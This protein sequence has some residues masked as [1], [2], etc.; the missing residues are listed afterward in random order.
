MKS[1]KQLLK[2]LKTNISK[3]NKYRQKQYK[4]G[5][6]RI[7]LQYM[8]LKFLD[9]TEVDFYQANLRFSD[10]YGANLENANLNRVILDF[11][12]LK[13]VNLRNANL[14]DAW[15]GQHFIQVNGIGLYEQTILYLFEDDIIICKD[16]KG[17]LKE[18]KKRIKEDYLDPTRLYAKQYNLFFENIKNLKKL[19][20]EQN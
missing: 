4:K 20:N 12:D 17:S 6:F 18:F 14:N 2:L 7:D 15:I 13:N 19:Y 10:L 5:I 9:L 8:D 11:V 1:K 16:F 3:F